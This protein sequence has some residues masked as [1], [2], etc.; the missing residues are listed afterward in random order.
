MKRRA[1]LGAACSLVA[2]AG[3]GGGEERPR[4]DIEKIERG[5][6]AGVVRNHPDVGV[7]SVTCPKDVPAKK[8]H[9][10]K[11]RVK[12]SGP[13]QEA[14]A[15]VTELDDKGRVRYVVPGGP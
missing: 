4:I 7:V 11:C 9:V 13:G 8:G 6:E 15:T 5:I 12:G 1:S 2:L 3:C 14:E 10:F